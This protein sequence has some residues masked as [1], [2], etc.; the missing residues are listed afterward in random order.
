MTIPE[1][2]IGAFLGS[3]LK[4]RNLIIDQ[5]GILTGMEWPVIACKGRP[6]TWRLLSSDFKP[7]VRPMSSLTKPIVVDGKEII[8]IVKLLDISVGLNWSDTD[9][10]EI[11]SVPG[12]WSVKIKGTDGSFG[13]NIDAGFYHISGGSFTLVRNQLALFQQLIAWSFDIFGWLEKGLA[14]EIKD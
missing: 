8:P 13:Y 3:K 2:Q 11:R 1:N 14:E 7:L 12:E 9:L 4:V 6:S 10:Y 5:V